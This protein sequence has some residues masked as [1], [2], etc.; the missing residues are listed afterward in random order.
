MQ[1]IIFVIG[2]LLFIGLVI[3]HE[4]GHFIAARRSGVYVEEFGLGFPPRAWGR[5]QKSGMILSLNWL[6]LGGFVKMKGEHD[7]DMRKGSFGAATLW[8]KTKIMLAGVTM[9]L[10]VALI[11]FTILA[12]VG[13]PSVISKDTIGEDQFTVASDTKVIRAE[14]LVGAIDKGSP[15]D[16]LGLK[17][18]DSILTIS[19]NGQTF[20]VKDRSHLQKATAALAGQNVQIIYKRQGKILAGF[21]RLVGMKEINKK[22]ISDAG[23]KPTDQIISLKDGSRTLHVQSEQDLYQAIEKFKGDSIQISY[24]RGGNIE[25]KD[26]TLI[27]PGHL[28]IIPNNLQVQRS[29][30]SAPV[31]AVGLSKQLTVLTF[32]GL[33]KAL[34]GLGSLVAGVATGNHQARVNG[35]SEASDQVGGPVAIVNALWNT[36]SLGFVFMLLIIAIISLTLAIMNILPIPALDGGRLFLMLVSRGV[37]KKPLSKA[38]EERIVGAGMAVLLLLVALITIVDV[39]RFF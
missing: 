24:A 1:L 3:V 31:V 16:R 32:K 5:K 18:S 10:L 2:F 17:S 23:L 30:W 7:S 35:Q 36:G 9:N 28:G 29:T 37:F 11:L 22:V 34:G 33:G 14:V 19:G 39:K 4:W 15:A 26:M 25:I 12:W 13:M 6:P 20:A 8:Q 21:T 38:M 27:P